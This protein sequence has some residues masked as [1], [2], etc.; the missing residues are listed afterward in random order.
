MNARGNVVAAPPKAV[1]SALPREFGFF[2]PVGRLG[3]ERNGAE[4]R[5]RPLV[6][7]E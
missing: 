2:A 1:L 6:G 5:P 4:L 3:V 7:K